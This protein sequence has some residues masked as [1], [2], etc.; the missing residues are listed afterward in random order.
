MKSSKREIQSR[1]HKMPILRFTDQT[2]SSFAGLI[3]FQ[4]LFSIL[5]LKK[6]LRSCFTHLNIGSIFGHHFI[7][8]LLVVHLLLGFRKLRDIDY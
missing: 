2:L 4:P 6:R 8:L 1:V 7:M 3:I 5:E